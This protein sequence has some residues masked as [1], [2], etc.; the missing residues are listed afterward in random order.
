MNDAAGCAAI[1]GQS[2]YSAKLSNFESS[3]TTELIAI[4][5]DI[6]NILYRHSGNNFTIFTDFDD[7]AARHNVDFKSISYL[8]TKFYSKKY[9]FN[10]FQNLWSSITINQKLRCIKP[11][12]SLWLSLL[13]TNRRD[14]GS[15]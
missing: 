15:K 9:T 8:D 10:K 13:S 3:C 12:I 14:K 1:I 6:K 11:N 4:L 7:K 5:L 2:V